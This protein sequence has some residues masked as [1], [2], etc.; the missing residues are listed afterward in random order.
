M[1]RLLICL[2]VIAQVG[3]SSAAWANDGGS[4]APPR[5]QIGSVG[6]IT[7][8]LDATIDFYTHVLGLTVVGTADVTADKTRG[9][10]GVHS[11][12]AV[13]Y[14]ALASQSWVEGNKSVA[15][16]SFFEVP[17]APSSN[18]T[19]NAARV[20]I[21]GEAVLGLNVDDVDKVAA[22]AKERGA[23][24]LAPLGESGTSRTSRSI[25][26]LDPNGIRVEVYEY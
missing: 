16:I 7:N 26:L 12:E 11:E 4:D 6:F 25:A 21:P 15:I 2:A 3:S 5:A 17:S 18:L 22:R 19:Q 20:S 24:V 13:R 14:V 10:I 1:K 9:V 23:T 8:D